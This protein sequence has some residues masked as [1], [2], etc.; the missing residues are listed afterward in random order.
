MP[1]E[2]EPSEPWKIVPLPMSSLTNPRQVSASVN[3]SP[4]PSPSK[5]EITGAFL[6]AKL[7]ARPKMIQFTTIRGIYTPKDSDKAG[8]YAFNK[9]S[10]IV[11]K[12]ATITINAGI[13]TP[14]GIFFLKREIN[15]FE[16]TKT[17]VVES[18]IPSPLI[19][20]EV[21]ARVGHIPSINTKVGFS[22]IIP[23]YKRST[24]LF[25]TV[26]LLLNSE[27]IQLL[28]YMHL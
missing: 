27:S 18:P 25:I 20:E 9:N 7:S 3:P 8:I 16:K 4:I 15:K 23:L 14:F 19:A 24:Y 5:M 1:N 22:L 28:H 26:H 6:E 11:T 21:T 13:R 2:S 17:T 10:T 12:E